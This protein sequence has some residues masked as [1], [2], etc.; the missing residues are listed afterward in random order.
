VWRGYRDE[1]EIGY[2]LSSEEWGPR[3]LVAQAVKAEEAGFEGLWISDH[4]HPWNDEQGHSPFVRMDPHCRTRDGRRDLHLGR[5]VLPSVR[6]SADSRAG[7]V[8]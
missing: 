8:S 1:D 7:R 4:F 5:E 6:R 3:E 2:F